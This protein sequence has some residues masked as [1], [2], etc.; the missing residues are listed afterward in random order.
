MNQ[1]EI[2][3]VK[4]FLQ[5]AIDRVEEVEIEVQRIF[6]DFPANLQPRLIPIILKSSCLIGFLEGGM[7]QMSKTED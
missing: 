7:E 6:E 5:K 3:K 1:Q 4:V 2:N